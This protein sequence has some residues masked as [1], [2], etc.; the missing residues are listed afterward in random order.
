MFEELSR[1]NYSLKVFL[2]HMNN[3]QNDQVLCHTAHICLD[4]NMIAERG[5]A[6]MYGDFFNRYN[7]L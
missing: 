4:T 5:V 6:F 2:S 7:G 3:E 1:N